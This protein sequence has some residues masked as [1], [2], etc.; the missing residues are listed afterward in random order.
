GFV[1]PSPAKYTWTVDSTS[2][3]VSEIDLIQINLLT[4]T[5]VAVKIS[6]LLNAYKGVTIS[7]EDPTT[8]ALQQLQ[9]QHDTQ[10]NVWSATFTNLPLGPHRVDFQTTDTACVVSPLFEAD[11]VTILPPTST[12]LQTL[13]NDTGASST[14]LITSDG[15]VTV[16]GIASEAVKSVE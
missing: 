14:D 11:T 4:P 13:K 3:A 8:G 16:S 5:E 9:A 12:I 1:D 6:D 2:P 15:S 7:V 10:A